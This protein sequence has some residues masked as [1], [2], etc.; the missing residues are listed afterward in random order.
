MISSRSSSKSFGKNNESEYS[1]NVSVQNSKSTYFAL[2]NCGFN[3][4]KTFV[5]EIDE[6]ICDQMKRFIVLHGVDE[7][8]NGSVYQTYAFNALRGNEEAFIEQ[9]NDKPAHTF[10]EKLNYLAAQSDLM[11]LLKKCEEV[12]PCMKN[13]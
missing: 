13:H 10:L 5:K 1:L 6:A 3:I 11:H 2:F 4:P 7:E 12:C 9:E 8:G